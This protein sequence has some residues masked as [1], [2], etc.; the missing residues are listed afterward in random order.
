MSN[1]NRFGSALALVI[2]ATAS[3]AE[4]EIRVETLLTGLR[5]PCGVAIRPGDGEGRCEVFVADSGALRV[6]RLW[7][8][9]PE[10]SAAAIT[11]FAAGTL[12]EGPIRVGP[13][14][15]LFLDRNR[16]IVGSSGN[17]GGAR[18]RLYA[19]PED[20]AE[21]LAEAAEHEVK[22]PTDTTGS[23]GMNHVYA[24]V[25]A[26][27]NEHVPDAVLLTS[28]RND[29]SGRLFQIPIRAGTLG[30][31]Q[32]F[33]SV[34]DSAAPE[35]VG[36]VSL[37]E[38]EHIVAGQVGELDESRDSQLV[39]YNPIDGARIMALP[40]ELHD[41]VGLAYSPK[42]GNL[43]A[44]DIAWMAPDEGG[45]YRIDDAGEAGK[46]RC[47]AVKLAAVARPSAL[48]FGPDGAM[49]VTAF[50]ELAD[51]KTNDGLLLKVVGEL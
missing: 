50:G 5:N 25:R 15:M 33:G 51:E 34:E 47:A 30:S 32:R 31:M 45:I 9:E 21:V 17:G 24:M 12:G 18:V 13:I 44:A 8:D 4:E 20:R 10:K 6:V 14:A 22:F 46:L 2:L 28:M 35:Q 3:F 19:L 39:F 49:Y 42:T 38:Q 23:G 16:L 26:R 36:E 7:S 29:R 37:A 11:G 41:V 27:A 40:L 48:A 1:A 43:Y